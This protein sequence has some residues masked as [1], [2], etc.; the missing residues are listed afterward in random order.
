MTDQH[1]TAAELALLKVIADRIKEARKRPEG[2]VAKWRP[3]DRNAA[4]LPNGEEIGAVTL[5]SGRKTARINDPA[6]LED[7]ARRT[8]PEA[9]ETVTIT[10]LNPQFVERLLAAAKKLG[11]PVDA[12]TGEEVPGIV[13]EQGDPYPQVRLAA[14][15]AE[16]V[17]AAWKDGEMADLVARLLR[18]AIEG[19]A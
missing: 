13:V 1:R 11:T 17:A 6:A 5:A 7:W 15:A 10:R 18:P 19:G 3:K 14:D 8:H 12:E 2:E 4:V 9:F 16:I